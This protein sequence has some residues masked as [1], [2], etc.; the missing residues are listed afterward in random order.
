MS[1]R[2][3]PD[4][5]KNLKESHRKAPEPPKYLI[6][7]NGE[8]VMGSPPKNRPANAPQIPSTSK[9]SEEVAPTAI[10]ESR[11]FS[12]TGPGRGTYNSLHNDHLSTGISY[13]ASKGKEVNSRDGVKGTPSDSSSGAPP[14]QYAGTS[15]MHKA[16]H[17][18]G[19]RSGRGFPKPANVV[20]TRPHVPLAPGK[21]EYGLTHN[22]K[23]SGKIMG[24][25][26]KRYT[27]PTNVPYLD[28]PVKVQPQAQATE[29]VDTDAPPYGVGPDNPSRQLN[30]TWAAYWDDEAGAVYY[31]R[32]DTGE[33]TWIPPPF[34]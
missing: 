24:D 29:V 5:P 28:E 4:L 3:V 33:A 8:V 17:F 7:P 34:P 6:G 9:W 14:I 30:D 19:S 10:R 18:Q 27:D 11:G 2:T 1:G 16:N 20:V 31:F 26:R 13:S 32:S 21:D 12:T 25:Y 22:R 15:Y 23:V